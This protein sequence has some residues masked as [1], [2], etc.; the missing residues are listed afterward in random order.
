[1]HHEGQIK[2]SRKW[3]ELVPLVQLLFVYRCSMLVCHRNLRAAKFCKCNDVQPNVLEKIGKNG[4][5]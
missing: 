2:S 5:K 1:M 4:S 3:R